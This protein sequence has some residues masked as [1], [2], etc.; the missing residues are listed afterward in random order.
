MHNRKNGKLRIFKS[1]K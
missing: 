1:T